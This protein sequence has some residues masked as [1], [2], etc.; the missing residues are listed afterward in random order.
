MVRTDFGQNNSAVFPG[1]GLRDFGCRTLVEVDVGRKLDLPD[2]FST[3][4]RLIPET[5]SFWC[6]IKDVKGSARVQ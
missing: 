2:S 5:F 6:K 3:H 1:L 4:S